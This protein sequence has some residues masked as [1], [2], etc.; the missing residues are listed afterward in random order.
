MLLVKLELRRILD[1][2][3][4]FAVVDKAG[5]GVEQ[6]RLARARAA[7]DEDAEARLHGGLEKFGHV[8]AQGVAGHQVFQVEGVVLK[9][10]NR[11]RRPVDA[12]GRDHHVDAAA[13]LQ[14]RIDAGAGLVHATAHSGDDAVDNRAQVLLVLEDDIL[15]ALHAAKALDKD[16]VVVV[17]HDLSDRGIADQHRERAVAQRFVED[18]VDAEPVL[19]RREDD[20]LAVDD[21]GEPPLDLAAAMHRLHTQ[22]LAQIGGGQKL[23]LQVAN[24]LARLRVH[25]RARRRALLLDLRQRGPLARAAVAG[26]AVEGV[27]VRAVVVIVVIVV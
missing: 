18:V 14:P 15:D 26:R 1:G 11:Q 2:D 7:G 21:V 23:A 4:A 12:E 24:L 13:V 8:V 22:Q 3:D 9:F 20:A 10:T 5:Q 16:A 19:L 17:D 27:A 25:G 6:R